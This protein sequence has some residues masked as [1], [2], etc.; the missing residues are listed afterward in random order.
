MPAISALWGGG[1]AEAEGSLR[2]R[3]QS[4]LHGEFQKN[5]KVGKPKNKQQQKTET[6][7]TRKQN[8]ISTCKA[9]RTKATGEDIPDVLSLLY[10]YSS[11]GRQEGAES[12]LQ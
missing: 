4:S 6:I 3:G 8:P 11:E 1:G 7:I 9:C 12:A 5:T 2:V 10:S